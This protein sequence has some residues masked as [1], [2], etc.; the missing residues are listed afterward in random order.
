MTL[1]ANGETIRIL[2]GTGIT[3]QFQVMILTIAVD[4][5]VLSASQVSTLTNKSIALQIT[6]LQVL[7]QNSI[8]P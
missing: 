3:Q 5:T 2:G 6:Q 1:S 4:G 7:Q 8:Q